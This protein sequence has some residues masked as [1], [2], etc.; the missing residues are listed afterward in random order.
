MPVY[1]ALLR[2]I[3]VGGHKIVKMAELKTLCESLGLRDVRTHLQSGNVVFRAKRSDQARLAKKLESAL[4]VESKVIVRSADEVRKAIE[5]NPMLA[6]A[7]R[8]PSHF[9]VVFLSGQ[10]STAAMKSLRD[11]YP[12]PEPMQLHG[13]ELYIHYGEGMARSKL[14]NVLIERKLGITGTARNWNTVT[15]LIVIADEIALLPET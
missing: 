11:A 9:I 1:I 8:E 3:N 7:E 14:T 4:S 5:A 2:G 10:P 13:S 12:G 6:D 15:R